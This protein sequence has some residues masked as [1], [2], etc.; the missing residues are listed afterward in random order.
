MND[1]A[2]LLYLVNQG[3]LTFHVWASRVSDLDRPDFVLFDL[4]PGRATFA[5]AAVVAKAVKASLEEE[6]AQ[7]FVKTS[8]KSGLHVL[9]PWT[10]AGG[11]DGARAWASE[12]A[13]RV[14]AELNDRATCDVRKA[15][16]GER[17]YIDVL[18]NARGHHAVP[19][20]VL[21]RPRR[22]RF[23]AAGLARNCREARPEGLH[24]ETGPCPACAAED[25]PHDRAAGTAQTHAER[26]DRVVNC[27]G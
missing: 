26:A 6:G 23:H 15:K 1:E 19:P 16:R 13:G 17:V 14:A 9:T 12:I 20:Y 8:G 7:S 3:T 4:D 25:R 21:C 27:P 22:D 24:D 11:Y 18:Q 5:D 2:T 10:Q